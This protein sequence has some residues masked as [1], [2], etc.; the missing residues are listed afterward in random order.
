MF[1]IWKQRYMCAC[2]SFTKSFIPKLQKVYCIVQFLTK[3]SV[4]APALNNLQ[5]RR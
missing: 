2:N 5:S 1:S 3:L 4:F